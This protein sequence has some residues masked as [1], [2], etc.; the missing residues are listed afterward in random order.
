M[1]STDAHREKH[2][3]IGVGYEP[4]LL[5]PMN[6]SAQESNVE[7]T[8]V[9]PSGLYDPAPNGYSHAVVADGGARVAYVAGQGGEH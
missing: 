8:I 1:R 9:N 6:V 4:A 7:L 5:T 2:P 3:F